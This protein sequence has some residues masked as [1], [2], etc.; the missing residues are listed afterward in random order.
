MITASQT[1]VMMIHGQRDIVCD[2][3]WSIK[4]WHAREE[5]TQIYLLPEHNHWS[6]LSKW[7][8]LEGLVLNWLDLY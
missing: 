7:D 4:I 1:P 5:D 3:D 2:F 6:Y 8:R